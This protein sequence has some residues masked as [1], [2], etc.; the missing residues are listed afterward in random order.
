[1]RLH[2][3]ITGGVEKNDFELYQEKSERDSNIN[4]SG[5]ADKLMGALRELFNTPC[6]RKQTAV[7]INTQEFSEKQRWNI[8]QLH[9]R[10]FKSRFSNQ[11]KENETD[12]SSVEST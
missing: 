1:M 4:M 8:D 6:S 10:S 12:V 7:K 11:T 2:D 9:V 3:Y 5:T